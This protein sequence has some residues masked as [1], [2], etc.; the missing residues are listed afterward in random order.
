[1]I[2]SISSKRAG[3]LT[4]GNPGGI[5]GLNNRPLFKF[6]LL[7]RFNI[8]PKMSFKKKKKNHKTQ[9]IVIFIF[10][11]ISKEFYPFGTFLK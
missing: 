5:L 9:N 2:I 1:M 8:R 10:L 4:Q 7:V 11:N 3:R 6:R